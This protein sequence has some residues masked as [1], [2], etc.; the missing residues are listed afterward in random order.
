MKKVNNVTAVI[1]VLLYA[2]TASSAALCA[3]DELPDKTTDG[4]T[5][6]DSKNVQALYWQDGATLAQYTK[7][8]LVDCAVAFRKD[9]MKDFNRERRDLSSRVSSKDMDRIKTALA[10]EFKIKFTEVLEDGGYEI[11]EETGDDVL[12]LRPALINLD[13][14]A[15]DLNNVGRSRNYVASAGQMTLYMEFYDSAT[16]AKIGEVVDAESAR[17]TGVMRVANRVTNKAEADIILKKW[18]NLLVDALD[19]AHGKS[20]N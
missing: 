8:M 18:A 17:D 2:L 5:R 11:V 13:V 3:D 14:T 19:E 7:V 1:A 16:S 10:Q 12:L 15:P 20:G 9:W 6:I 4:L